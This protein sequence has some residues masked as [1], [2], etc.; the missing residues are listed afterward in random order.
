MLVAVRVFKPHVI[1]SNFIDLGV[2]AFEASRVVSMH[3]I[4]CECY[5]EEDG[6]AISL[7]RVVAEPKFDDPVRVDQEGFEAIVRNSQYAA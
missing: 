5:R 7:W 4:A 6:S 2:Y 3:P 1:S